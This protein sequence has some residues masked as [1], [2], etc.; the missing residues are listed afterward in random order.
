MFRITL[1]RGEYPKSILFFMFI[2]CFNFY[3]SFWPYHIAF[4]ILVPWPGI[5]PGPCQWKSWVLVPGPLGNSF[6]SFSFSSIYLF[7]L[8]KSWLDYL[9]YNNLMLLE[10]LKKW[11]HIAFS[12]YFINLAEL[13]P[14]YSP[15]P[16]MGCVGDAVGDVALAPHLM[17]HVAWVHF[18]SVAQVMSDSLR[19]HESQYAR[20]PCPSPTPGVYSNSCPSSRWCHPA[21]LS[22]FIPFSSCPNPSWVS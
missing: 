5:E 13:P 1:D 16:T 11:L 3:L 20:P 18:S 14:P 21:I 22:S 6:F 12:L 4:G 2:S 8:K 10:I 17:S 7:F 15:F 19:P 9:P